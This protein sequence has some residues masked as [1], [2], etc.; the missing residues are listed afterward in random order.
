MEVTPGDD[1]FVKP[2]KIRKPDGKV[3]E[4]L[5]PLELLITHSYESV[6]RPDETSVADVLAPLALKDQPEEFAKGDYDFYGTDYHE[7]VVLF[8]WRIFFFRFVQES[9][10]IY[11]SAVQNSLDVIG[12]FL[13]LDR[14]IPFLGI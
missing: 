10:G 2:A 8:P 11:K 12:L 7:P 4:H 1:D 14:Y 3:Q 6:N 13:N 9:F 5:Y